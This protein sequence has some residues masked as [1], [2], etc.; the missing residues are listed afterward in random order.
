MADAPVSETSLSGEDVFIWVLGLLVLSVLIQRIPLYLQ[1]KFGFGGGSPYL[2]SGAV[3]D[4][5]TPSGSL[6]TLPDGG[7]YY[8]EPEGEEVGTFPP[9][10]PLTLQDFNQVFTTIWWR[11]ESG[12]GVQ[13]WIES[14][15]L[16]RADVGGVSATTT[17][18]SFA[19]MLLDTTLWSVPG[20]G[21]VATT[22]KKGDR[23]HL[24]E[25]QNVGMVPWWFVKN[26]VSG[27]QGW[28]PSSVL[29][30]TSD[31]EWTKDTPLV[32]LHDLDLF[33]SAGGGATKAVVREGEKLS[34]I[35]GPEPLGEVFWWQ[36]ETKNE[37][38]G[39]AP[40]TSL[41]EGGVAGATR[42][43]L[44][45]WLVV[46]TVLT[47]VLVI[48]IVFVALRTQ[49]VRKAETERILAH[50]A[51]RPTVQKNARWEKVLAHGATDNPNDWRLAILEADVMLD[52][53]VATFA[54]AGNTLGERLKQ[55][56]KGDFKTLDNAWEAH[57]IR[58]TIAHTGTEFVLSKRE[59]Q[60]VLELYASVLREF[61]VI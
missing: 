8:D 10:V 3:V 61:H 9:G 24:L 55:A 48:G 29:V 41:T 37:E 5:T 28:V 2:V 44:S 45:L 31:K 49:Q 15:R 39:W 1:E 26:E 54:Y 4:K 36:V 50:V 30:R 51:Q 21:D 13:G 17:S 6:V 34:I 35:G 56:N 40:E 23:V 11:V 57:R 42:S 19:R 25:E 32:A 52:E 7:A 20:G 27:V 60:R 22:T 38:Q 53:L 58:N 12:E 47:I 59:A 46:G 14:T 33:E 43:L 16:I 18:G